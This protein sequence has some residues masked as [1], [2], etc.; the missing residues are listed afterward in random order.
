VGYYCVHNSRV[1]WVRV[2]PKST[3]NVRERRAAGSYESRSLAATSRSRAA[4]GLWSRLRGSVVSAR[5]PP[6]APK[7]LRSRA[8]GN[9]KEGVKANVV[10]RAARN[11]A[12]S[13]NV[14]LLCVALALAVGM[15]LLNGVLPTLRD[16]C[17]PAS[18]QPPCQPSRRA[19]DPGG[20]GTRHPRLRK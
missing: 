8:P 10:R 13:V 14:W 3:R 7:N 2:S 9:A 5:M 6:L 4:G 16:K 12:P 17:G 18:L 15:F 1:R 20:L 19:D 11:D